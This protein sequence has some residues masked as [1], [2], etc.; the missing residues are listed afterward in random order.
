MM[1]F[2]TMYDL[3]YKTVVEDPIL[4][5]LIN[6]VAEEPEESTFGDNL[7]DSIDE[8]IIDEVTRLASEDE[9]GENE[10]DMYLTRIG[11]LEE[12]APKP[13]SFTMPLPRRNPC[14]DPWWA[15]AG[16]RTTI[17]SPA[18]TGTPTGRS[19]IVDNELY[20]LRG[21]SAISAR[22]EPPDY[23]RRDRTARQ[24]YH[25]EDWGNGEWNTNLQ[26]IAR[27]RPRYE[28]RVDAD[29]ISRR[30]FVDEQQ[31][32]ELDERDL[33]FVLR[34]LS[35]E[36][37]NPSYLRID[38]DILR[39]FLEHARSEGLIDRFR[40]IQELLRDEFVVVAEKGQF[41]KNLAISRCDMRR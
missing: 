38:E 7:R 12:E 19:N 23:R 39:G 8:D 41:R 20:A 9:D 3:L 37:Y 32:A 11:Y 35:E 26:E 27:Y 17:A 28:A 31:S 13:K 29:G 25:D 22:T 24:A 30:Y 5:E 10:D 1:D 6:E 15:P 14:A 4:R 33:D 36:V 18:F 40:I 21:F 2:K 34:R 16:L